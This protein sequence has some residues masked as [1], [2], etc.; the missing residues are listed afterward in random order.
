LCSQPLI[1]H[2]G[3]GEFF[4]CCDQ[5]TW[6][7][8]FNFSQFSRSFP[9]DQVRLGDLNLNS[10]HDDKYAQQLEIEQII[11]HPNYRFSSSYDD[12][13]LLRLKQSVKL[14]VSYLHFYRHFYNNFFFLIRIHDTVI[15]A[16]LWPTFN[17]NF[18]ELESAGWGLTSFGE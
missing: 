13:A 11:T 5:F 6:V 1:V 3:R 15:P 18:D 8:L 2:F 10:T 16:C 7:Q 14:V 12:I 17:F 4:F 9:P